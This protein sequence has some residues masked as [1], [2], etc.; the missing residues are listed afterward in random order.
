MRVLCF[1][2]SMAPLP[3]CHLWDFYLE[4][5][6]SINLVLTSVCCVRKLN[7]VLQVFWYCEF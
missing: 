2:I 1:Q 6:I 3:H 5:Q 7:Y 4:S